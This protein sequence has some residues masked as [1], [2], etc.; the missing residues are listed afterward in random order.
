MSLSKQLKIIT[1]N[2]TTT[3]K[4]KAFFLHAQ[5]VEQVSKR[6]DSLENTISSESFRLP[7]LPSPPP[8]TPPTPPPPPPPT[9]DVDWLTSEEASELFNDKWASWDLERIIEEKVADLINDYPIPP[10]PAPT[11]V[12]TPPPPPAPPIDT[13]SFL[14]KEGYLSKLRELQGQI[15]A[16]SKFFG[17]L[18]SV[19]GVIG[20]LKGEV[21]EKMGEMEK[22]R[23]REEKE[24]GEEKEEGKRE[25]AEEMRRGEER[26]KGLVRDFE[27][28]LNVLEVLFFFIFL[29]FFFSLFSS[30]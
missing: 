7:S 20:E 12:P 17:E 23:E 8:P 19:K 2:H 26:L 25:W 14:E 1:N 29:F 28:T 21:R 3:T 9:P 13:T 4:Q 5:R 15:N 24:R 11:P 22:E 10:P 16:F 18:E 27:G 6:V 30:P